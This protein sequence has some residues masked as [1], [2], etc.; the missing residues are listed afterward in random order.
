MSATESLDVWLYGTHVAVITRS[1]RD[2]LTL[3][4]TPDALAR[5]G[6]DST[7]LGAKLPVGVKI[8]SPLVRTYLDGLLP[9]G[10]ARVNHALAAGVA[11]DDTF[12]L[13]RAYGRDTPGAAQIV[14]SGRGDPTRPVT[15]N[16]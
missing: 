16:P 14:E 12:A 2:A 9:E 1:P 8:L 6:T 4:W 3:D 7:V 10:N 13:V 5:F 11:P 15:T